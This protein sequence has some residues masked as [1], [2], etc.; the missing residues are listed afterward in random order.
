[1]CCATYKSVIPP[2]TMTGNFDALTTFFIFSKFIPLSIPSA[3]ISV[4]K[5]PK[6]LL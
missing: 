4:N 3:F 5:N 6:H 2:E 1:M